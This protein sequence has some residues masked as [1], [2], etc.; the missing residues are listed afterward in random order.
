MLFACIAYNVDRFVSP[1]CP[2]VEYVACDFMYF[3]FVFSAYSYDA[4]VPISNAN[5]YVFIL[6]AYVIFTYACFKHRQYFASALIVVVRKYRSAYDRQSGIA[7]YK[8]MGEG[9]H[10]VKQSIKRIAV[11][12]HRAMFVGKRDYMLVVILIRR[13]LN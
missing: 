8:V 13:I 6:I 10:K 1:I 12:E 2:A 7:S 11:D 9:I 5:T 3:K 4:V